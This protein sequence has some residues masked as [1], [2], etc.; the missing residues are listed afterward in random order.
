M[1]KAALSN[2]HLTGIRCELE[3]P[4]TLLS[5]ITTRSTISAV[6]RVTMRIVAKTNFLVEPHPPF[7]FTSRF[8]S[9]SRWWF[10]LQIFDPCDV[11]CRPAVNNVR[12]GLSCDELGLIGDRRVMSRGRAL[13][14]KSI[15]CAR[16]WIE[17]SR[18]C[19]LRPVAIV[20][21]VGSR[22]NHSVGIEVCHVSRRW[23]SVLGEGFVDSWSLSV[24]IQRVVSFPS[25]A[26]LALQ[27]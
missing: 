4:I 16:W 20:Q 10:S 21:W 2:V 14:D 9:L 18:E 8:Q 26:T 27:L 25:L 23:Q 22:R 12:S 15:G 6:S 1:D 13:S 19:D 3:W 5:S 17:L 7:L 11:T 24:V